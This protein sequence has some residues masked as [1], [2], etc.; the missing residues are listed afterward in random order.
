[1]RCPPRRSSRAQVAG[2]RT[3]ATALHASSALSRKEDVV[4]IRINHASPDPLYAQIRTQIIA[5]IAHGEL[6]PGDSL[7]SVRALAADLGVNLHT[8]NKAYAVL[9][10]EG[11]V[12]MRGRSGAFVADFA[13]DAAEGSASVQARISEA[14]RQLALEHKAAGGAFGDFIEEARRQAQGVYAVCAD[15]PADC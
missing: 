6:R 15:C 10:D 5:A 2:Q 3:T 11:Y 7:P 9:R 1:M 14:L 12:L 4:I 8:V 13:R